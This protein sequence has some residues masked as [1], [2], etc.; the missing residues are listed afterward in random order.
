[1]SEN[2]TFG[3]MNRFNV[4]FFEICRLASIFLGLDKDLSRGI[5]MLWN[6]PMLAQSVGI[7]IK[8][9]YY[10][11]LFT[12]P[13]LFLPVWP[14]RYIVRDVTFLPLRWRIILLVFYHIFI[15]LLDRFYLF[16]MLDSFYRWLLG[17]FL[18]FLWQNFCVI[19]NI[20]LERLRA[21]WLIL[22]GR[23]YIK[24]SG[25]LIII[26]GDLI[27]VASLFF[28]SFDIHVWSGH[29]LLLLL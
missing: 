2:S 29:I 26:N 14:F 13:C 1:M 11:Y 8:H 23:I 18:F 27:W 10:L 17:L 21:C 6:L 7:I 25:P 9:V 4:V 24:G 3:L 28:I 12:V 15:G 16:F 5:S 20:L 22:N 19:L